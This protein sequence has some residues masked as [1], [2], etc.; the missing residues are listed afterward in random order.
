MR[1]FDRIRKR[2]EE[3]NISYKKY[4]KEEIVE[5]IDR[6]VFDLFPKEGSWTSGCFTR[7]DYLQCHLRDNLWLA[8]WFKKKLENKYIC[9]SK[10][11]ILSYIISSKL[12]EEKKRMS[13]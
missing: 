10:M 6:E 13:G 3:E 2:K 11:D 5:V 12:F 1:L 9:I 8:D 7:G 4:T